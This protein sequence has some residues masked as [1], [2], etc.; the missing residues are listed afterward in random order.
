A[1]GGAAPVAGRMGTGAV[2]PAGTDAEPRT[3]SGKWRVHAAGK[4]LE[5]EFRV[6]AGFEGRFGSVSSR[7]RQL[8]YDLGAG[9]DRDGAARG[10]RSRELLRDPGEGR[11]MGIGGG[12][13]D[14]LAPARGP[15][16]DR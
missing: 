4:G 16:G 10:P 12:K 6:R 9:P 8:D 14:P 13:H 15:S 11:V 1:R 5:E 7:Q 3:G 2:P